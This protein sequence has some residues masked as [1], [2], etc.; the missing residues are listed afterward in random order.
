M[1]RSKFLLALVYLSLI[2]CT[3]QGDSGT[4]TA[5]G[6]KP[7]EEQVL[8]LYIWNDYL[9]P[10]TLANFEKQPGIKVHV[11]YFDSNDTL[12]ARLLTGNSSF[13]VVLPSSPFL[14]RQIR[15]GVYQPLDKS[16]LPNL[17]NLDPVIM[18]EVA[19]ND[20]GNRYAIVYAWGTAG[21]GYDRKRASAA[22][23]G[24]TPTTWQAVF[25]PLQA[26]KLASCGINFLDEPPG[27]VRLVL[28]ALGRN[29]NQLTP[30]NLA[31]AEVAL[32]KVRPFVKTIDGSNYIQALANGD[33]CITIGYNGDVVQAR[34]RAK[35][36]QN[37]IDIGYA[38]PDEGSVLWFDMAAIPKDAPHPANAHRFLNYLMV[39]QT[40]ADI[41]NAVGFA[42]ANSAATPLVHP[43]IATHAAIYPPP[44]QQSRLFVQSEDS[45]DTARAITRLWQRFKTGQ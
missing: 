7:P 22:L 39:P 17:A 14:N 1:R 28:K 27:M 42:N 13:D 34:N 6:A 16:Q 20:P 31:A 9:A 11:A 12:E 3:K 2:A 5:A 29:P 43:M 15:S 37:G 30:E 41:T 36:A 32:L 25:N 10:D 35:D 8:N 4:P 40:M 38:I 19:Q 26:A 18:S 45:P 44:E 24:F 33:I 21:I 23:A